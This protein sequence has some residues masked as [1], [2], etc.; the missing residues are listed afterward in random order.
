MHVAKVRYELLWLFFFCIF[1]ISTSVSYAAP[2][3]KVTISADKNSVISGGTATL[4]WRSTNATTASM[5]PGIGTVDL[6]G[7]MPVTLFSTTTYT[8]TVS[9]DSRTKSENVTVTVVQGNSSPVANDDTVST[10]RDT[11]VTINVL[12]NDTDADGE[13]LH[14]ESFTQPANGIVVDNGDETVTYT[15]NSEFTGSSYSII[16]GKGGTDS[17]Q[18]IIAINQTTVDPPSNV[19]SS[20]QND[21]SILITWSAPLQTN[22]DNYRVYKRTAGSEYT[23]DGYSIVP[24]GSLSYTEKRLNAGLAYF[25]RITA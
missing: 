21:N 15:P 25:Y 16:D 9:S 8:I 22:I 19:A 7:S 5:E 18:V 17:A 24:A 4:T 6:N 1:L 10:N 3:P 13:I 2:P 23:N 20:F 14:L 11:P 12:A